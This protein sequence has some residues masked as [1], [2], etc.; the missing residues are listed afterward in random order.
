MSQL[1]VYIL[2]DDEAIRSSLGR[3]LVLRGY[4]VRSFATAESFLSTWDGQTL[5]C[6]ILDYGL[7]GE[8][9]LEVQRQLV[10]RQSALPIVFITG[11]GGVPESVQAIKAGAL[12]FLEKPFRQSDLLDRIETA[13]ALSR[14]RY[15][16]VQAD[17]QRDARFSRLTS[18]E[19]EIAQWIIANPAGATSKEI[20]LQLGIS[21]RT[22]DHHRAR[23]LEKLN[24][25]SIAEMIALAKS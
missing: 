24:V 20:A 11:H 14:E 2:D 25:R 21:P 13:F 18:R 16:S 4:T 8:S 5:G 7:P 15:S 9:G 10:E 6:L 1:V 23:I 22:V 3:A 17:R 12:D 19:L